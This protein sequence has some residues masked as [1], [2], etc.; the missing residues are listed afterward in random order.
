MYSLPRLKQKEIENTN[1][2]ITSI[3]T[4][5]VNKQPK[6]KKR[7]SKQKEKKKTFNKQ[8]SS[9]RELQR[10]IL[11]NTKNS[12]CAYFSNYSKNWRERNAS[13]PILQGQHHPD[14]KT[15][16]ITQK[17]E[18]YRPMS[19][20]SIDIEILNKILANW[21]QQYI[22]G[23]IQHDS[24]LGCRDGSIFTNQSMGYT[25]LTNWRRKIA[26]DDTKR[27]KQVSTKFSINLW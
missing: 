11:P 19:L 26:Y 12:K 1:R 2:L 24:S 9:T 18:N 27:Q 13:K 3:E 22:K 10:W 25:T 4:E 17:K 8:K 23:I 15:K 21:I 14:T 5:S 20:M 6:E 16:D 7:T